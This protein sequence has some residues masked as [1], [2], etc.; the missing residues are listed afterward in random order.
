MTK[1]EKKVLSLLAKMCLAQFL[2][3]KPLKIDECSNE[4]IEFSDKIRILR[5]GNT[6]SVS[7]WLSVFSSFEFLKRTNFHFSQIYPNLKR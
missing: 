6:L 7:G 4:K 3:N 2:L 1:W 5:R